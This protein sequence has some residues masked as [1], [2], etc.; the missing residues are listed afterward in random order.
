MY[1]KKMHQIQFRQ[2]RRDN[3]RSM[4]LIRNF[5]AIGYRD[6]VVPNLKQRKEPLVR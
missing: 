6:S 4:W 5:K 2:I 3:C 1:F